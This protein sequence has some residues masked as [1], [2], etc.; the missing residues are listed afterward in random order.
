MKILGPNDTGRGILLEYDAGYVSY[1]DTKKILFYMLF[2]RNMI[3]QTK[4]VEYIL[5]FY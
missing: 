5:N 1:E 3:P 2:Y 4:M